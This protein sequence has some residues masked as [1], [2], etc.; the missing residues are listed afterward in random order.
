MT[1]CIM[2]CGGWWVLYQVLVELEHAMDL[3]AAVQLLQVP[4]FA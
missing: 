3:A 4:S 2:L 1:W